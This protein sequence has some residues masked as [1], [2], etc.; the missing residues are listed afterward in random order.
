[1]T[2]RYSKQAL[3]N[4]EEIKRFLMAKFSFREVE[5][6]YQLLL[7]FEEVVVKF[8]NIYP[9][10][11]RN[12]SIRQAV[13]SKRLTLYYTVKKNVIFIISMKDNRQGRFA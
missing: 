9:T 1:M 7:G 5:Q 2:V 10:S 13:L 3:A 12:V 11:S 4:A 6:F 8:H